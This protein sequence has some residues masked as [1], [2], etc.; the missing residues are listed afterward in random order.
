MSAK[1]AFDLVVIGAGSGG[2]R[3][4]RIAAGYGAK[5]ALVEKQ[6]HHGAPNYSAIGGTCVNVGC[7]PKKLMTFGANFPDS[8]ELSAFYGW[9]TPARNSF[10][11][12]WSAMINRKNKEITRLNE[13]YASMLKSSGVELIDGHGTFENHNTIRVGDK[14]ITADK[15][16]IAVGAWPRVPPIPGVEHAIT[17]NEIFYLDKLPKHATIIGGGFIATEFACILNGYGCQVTQL[18]RDELLRGFDAD[19]RNG[20]ATELDNQGIDLRIGVQ[21]AKIDK[22]AQGDFN[23]SLNDCGDDCTSINTNLILNA[24]GTFASFIFAAQEKNLN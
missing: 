19:L 23:I 3:A 22:K 2:V 21:P 15:I 18:V 14:L 11:A 24:T 7:V 5:V 6:L 9:N 16:L 20:L 10:E 1:K 4:S 17:S 13:V 12:D 8:F